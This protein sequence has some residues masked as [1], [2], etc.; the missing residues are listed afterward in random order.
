[1]GC[2]KTAKL[3]QVLHVLS[4]RWRRSVES[5]MLYGEVRITCL[6]KDNMGLRLIPLLLV[7]LAIKLSFCPLMKSHE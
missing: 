2:L 6:D 5:Y 3:R 7:P 4:I 1:M